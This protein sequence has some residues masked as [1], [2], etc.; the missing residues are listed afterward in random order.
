MNPAGRPSW[1]RGI[2][3]PSSDKP[4]GTTMIVCRFGS[5]DTVTQFHIDGKGNR[6]RI[7]IRGQL[8]FLRIFQQGDRY[9]T[10]KIPALI[11]RVFNVSSPMRTPRDISVLAGVNVPTEAELA[12]PHGRFQN[13]SKKG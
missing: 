3:Q 2:S 6:I 13:R 5:S 1:L 9:V 12:S 4:A 7:G 8:S 10:D 11:R